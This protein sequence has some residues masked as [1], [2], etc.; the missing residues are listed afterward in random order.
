MRTRTLAWSGGAVLVVGMLDYGYGIFVAATP[1]VYAEDICR[2]Q[3][4]FSPL[5]EHP[6]I[7]RTWFP[8]SA[9]CRWSLGDHAELVPSFVFPMFWTLLGLAGVA[10][11]VA[12]TRFVRARAAASAALP[13]PL[14]LSPVGDSAARTSCDQSEGNRDGTE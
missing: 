12:A 10:L 3:L 7:S 13:P 2:R 4:H 5:A 6:V 9:T 11:A 1:D 8:P 14:P